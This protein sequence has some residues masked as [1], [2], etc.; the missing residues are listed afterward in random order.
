MASNKST[1]NVSELNFDDIKT[2]LKTYLRSQTEFSDY[3][4]DSSTLSILLDVLAY[5]TYHNSFYLN[6]VGNEMFLDSAQLRNSVVS[7]AKMLNYV[8]RSA[9]GATAALSAVITPDDSPTG[10]TVPANTQFTSTIDGIEYTFVTSGAT[11]MSPQDNGTFTGTLNIVEGTPL[12]HRFTVSTA[13]PVRY[14][15]PNENTDTTSFTVRIQESSSNTTVSTYNLAGDL[16]SVN[17]TSK[18]Y[19]VQENEDNLYEIQF[20]DNIFGKKP[21]DGNIIIVDYRV[22]S[23]NTVN[24]A[25]TFSAPES[26]AGYSNFTI[27]T[28]SSAQGGAPQETIDSIKFNAPFKFQAQDRLVTKQDYKNIILSEQG[29]IQSISVWGGEENI[30]AVYGKVFIATKPLSGAILSNQRKEAIRTSLKTRNTVSIDVEMVDAT[31]LY[32]NPTI[33]VR[34]NPQTTSLT[35]GE[36]NTII[37]NSLISYESN[38]LGTFDQKFYLYKMIETIKDVNSSFVSVDADITIEKRFIPLT[39]TNTYQLVFNQAVYHPHEG[40]L[41]GLV[42]TSSFTIDGISGQK[43]DDNGYGILRSFTQTPAGKVYRNRNFGII[44][45][46]TGLVTINNTL[47]SAYDGEYLSVKV[48]PRNKNIFASRNQILLISGATISTVDDNTNNIT[49]TVGTVATAGVST[50]INTE[51][52]IAT[53]SSGFTFTV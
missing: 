33:T 9:R 3:D 23:G 28:T 22:T 25:N 4:F 51:N 1:L 42:S 41:N 44:D 7:R 37:Q 49:S 47:I 16:S 19:F 18:I 32:I 14:I 6:M 48:K 43:I 46:D 5:N 35:A 15:L 2:S 31:Y 11:T 45:Y 27:T 52:A 36:L 21:I 38:N 24:G 40:H 20:G 34:Y 8:P 13:N 12:Q 17:S 50:T 10:V 30:P 29:D 39:T 53:T 26:L